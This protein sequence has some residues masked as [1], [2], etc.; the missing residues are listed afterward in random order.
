MYVGVRLIMGY[1]RKRKRC[2]ILLGAIPDT[3]L[4]AGYGSDYSGADTPGLLS[5]TAIRRLL[6]SGAAIFR[7]FHWGLLFGSC[8]GTGY[9]V[10]HC[11]S[12]IYRAELV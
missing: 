11:D 7:G 1:I 3:M 12:Y 8:Q 2:W 5:R 4:D 6:Y 9:R 10:V